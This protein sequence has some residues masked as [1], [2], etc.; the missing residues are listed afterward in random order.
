MYTYFSVKNKNA[1]KIKMH[2]LMKLTA[3]IQMCYVLAYID[4]INSRLKKILINLY[5]N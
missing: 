5:N 1:L 4:K 2:F 3:I